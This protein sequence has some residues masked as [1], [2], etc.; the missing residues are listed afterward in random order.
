M[1]LLLYGFI[2]SRCVNKSWVEIKIMLGLVGWVLDK[3]LFV[4]DE[5]WKYVIFFEVLYCI[6]LDYNL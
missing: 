3:C 1:F 6:F 4:V 5:M 2:K